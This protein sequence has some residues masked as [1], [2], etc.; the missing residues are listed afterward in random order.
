MGMMG[1]S[2]GGGAFGDALALIAAALWAATTILIRATRLRRADP[3]KVL[4]YQIAAAAVIAP[5]AAWAL[6]EPAPAHVSAATAAVL[7]WQ[8]AAVV[9]VSY[10][11]WFWLLANYAAAQLSAFTFVTPL[12]GV[13]AGWPVFGEKVTGGFAAAIALVLAGL[14][15]VNWPRKALA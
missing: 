5:L 8:G 14:A 13:F 1:R 11:M 3:V 9:A 7:L 12:V 15:P 2:A 10:V 6:G 4:L